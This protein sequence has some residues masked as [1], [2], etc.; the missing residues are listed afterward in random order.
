MRHY[1]L[2]LEPLMEALLERGYDGLLPNGNYFERALFRATLKA[3]LQ[4]RPPKSLFVVEA[5]CI[6]PDPV[7]SVEQDY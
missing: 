4:V 5:S 7:V 3:W 6:S 2:Q 1:A